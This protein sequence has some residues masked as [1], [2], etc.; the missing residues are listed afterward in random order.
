[1]TYMLELLITQFYP[2][3]L[4]IFCLKTNMIPRSSL[5]FFTAYFDM[6][7]Y[8]L[9]SLWDFVM[10][11]FDKRTDKDIQRKGFFK[12]FRTAYIKNIK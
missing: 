5:N 2:S 7:S 9:E 3:S 8:S 6:Y 10:Y 4:Y 12:I 11:K 1:M